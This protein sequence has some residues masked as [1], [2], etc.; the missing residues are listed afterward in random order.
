VWLAAAQ[1]A[2]AAAG[3]LQ[4]TWALSAQLQLAPEPFHAAHVSSKEQHQTQ[5]II[6]VLVSKIEMA[7]GVESRTTVCA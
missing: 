5:N 7:G 3:L 2:S 6:N 4:R 1:L